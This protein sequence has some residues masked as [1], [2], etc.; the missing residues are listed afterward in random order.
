[1][2]ALGESLRERSSQLDANRQEHSALSRKTKTVEQALDSKEARARV[3]LGAHHSV[4]MPPPNAVVVDARADG[5]G[6]P[7]GNAGSGARL[8]ESGSGQLP[9]RVTQ[10]G[11][12]CTGVIFPSLHPHKC[13]STPN[14]GS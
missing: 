8:S 13:L 14:A 12:C 5:G 4:T 3:R 1:M 10:P 9:G 7:E 6:A 11:L 2:E